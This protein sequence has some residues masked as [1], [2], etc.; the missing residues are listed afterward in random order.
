M[1]EGL[2]KALVNPRVLGGVQTGEEHL[3]VPPSSMDLIA[4]CSA[5]VDRSDQAGH[6]DHGVSLTLPQQVSWQ[7][8]PGHRGGSTIRRN[9]RRQ[10]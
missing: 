7:R 6:P 2:V 9:R 5:S 1:V 4:Q 8:L 10:R 3:L